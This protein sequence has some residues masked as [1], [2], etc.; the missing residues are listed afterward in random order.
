MKNRSVANIEKNLNNARAKAHL[1]W[2][3]YSNFGNRTNY[4]YHHDLVTGVIPRLL[5]ELNNKVKQIR[6][7]RTVKRAARYWVHRAYA[8]GGTSYRRVQ[9]QTQVGSKRRRTFSHL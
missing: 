7:Q 2:S 9:G 8:P 5:K 3:N 4:W 6:T 1:K